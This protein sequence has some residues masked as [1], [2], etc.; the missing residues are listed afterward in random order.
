M[1]AKIQDVLKAVEDFKK[2]SRDNM[3]KNHNELVQKFETLEGKFSE[4]KKNYDLVVAENKVLKVEVRSLSI[5]VNVARQDNLQRNLLIKGL[6]EDEETPEELKKI[7]F[8]MFQKL[9]PDFPLYNILNVQ[10]LGKKRDTGYRIVLVEL[11][12]TAARDQLLF[13]KKKVVITNGDVFEL[14]GESADRGGKIF[15]DEHLTKEMLNLFT[16]ARGLK[17]HGIGFVWVKRG[18]IFARA[19]NGGQLYKIWSSADVAVLKR[20][21]G[22][23]LDKRNATSSPVISDDSFDSP[24]KQNIAPF[25]N[26]FKATTEGNKNKKPKQ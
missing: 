17:E 21:Y 1:S 6:K 22:K 26:F 2:E 5:M 15:F 23:N 7:V 25:G 14:T 3:L 19:E 9:Q 10:R 12:H 20:K 8:N 16:M 18:K 13:L 4:L 11:T 24:A